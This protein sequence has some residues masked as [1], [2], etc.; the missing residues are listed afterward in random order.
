[1]KDASLRC[2]L[3]LTLLLCCT[4][5]KVLILSARLTVS[6]SSSQM[7]VGESVS[8]S[9]EEDDSS[10]GILNTPTKHHYTPQL[11]TSKSNLPPRFRNPTTS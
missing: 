8:L 10:A 11:L 6:P 7:F 9:C 3:S 2:L 1:M 4:S 5:T